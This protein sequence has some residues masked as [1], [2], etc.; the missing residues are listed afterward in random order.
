MDVMQ[1][2]NRLVDIAESHQRIEDAPQMADKDMEVMIEKYGACDSPYMK[3][4]ARH[5]ASYLR[6]GSSER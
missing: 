2:P 4:Y 1:N 3:R 6:N 5:L